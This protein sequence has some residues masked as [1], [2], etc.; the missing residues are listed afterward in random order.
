MDLSQYVVT[1]RRELGTL[2]RFAA[3]DV[4]RAAGLLAEALDSPVRLILLEALSAAAAEITARLDDTVVD[5]RLNGGEPEFVVTTVPVDE[6][7]QPAAATPGGDGS[8]GAGTARVTLRLSESLKVRVEAEAAS[9]GLSVNAWLVRAA[10]QA[11]E[12]PG[13]FSGKTYRS[14]GQ[15]ITGYARS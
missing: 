11:A 12:S 10:A 13:T 7:A 4:A 1:L 14:V 9:A 5:L 15:R 8:D 3:D 2:T 6:P